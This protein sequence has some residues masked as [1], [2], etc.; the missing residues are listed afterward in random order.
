MEDSRLKTAFFNLLVVVR[1]FK[2]SL[3]YK[4]HFNGNL[5]KSLTMTCVDLNALCCFNFVNVQG[6][7]WGVLKDYHSC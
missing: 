1:S 4:Q 3:F 6:T 5:Q 2:K 7:A